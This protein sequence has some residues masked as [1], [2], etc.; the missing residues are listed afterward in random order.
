MGYKC[1]AD[2][3]IIAAKQDSVLDEMFVLKENEHSKIDGNA[4][5]LY[6]K[7]IFDSIN[8]IT[9]HNKLVVPGRLFFNDI[10]DIVDHY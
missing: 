6:Y 4:L 2:E 10:M 1:L 9:S 5:Y 7:E 8:G 3:H